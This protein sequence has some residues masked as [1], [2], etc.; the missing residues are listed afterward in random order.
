M[1][2]ALV[3]RLSV[4]LQ[5]LIAN[6][7][8]LLTPFLESPRSSPRNNPDLKSNRSGYNDASIPASRLEP[9]LGFIS[10]GIFPTFGISM[11]LPLKVLELSLKSQNS[12]FVLESF[13]FITGHLNLRLALLYRLYMEKVKKK[14]RHI[15][16]DHF[17]IW[18]S[19]TNVEYAFFLQCSK[20]LMNDLIDLQWLFVKKY[21]LLVFSS[22]ISKK[23]RMHWT[24]WIIFRQIVS[25]IH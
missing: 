12:D 10:T 5:W 3:T 15:L 20:D 1:S 13:C 18:K 9:V 4:I 14:L 21:L 22:K 2:D 17:L 16:K 11:T 19:P 25:L 23:F 24:A 7:I 8:K 6:L